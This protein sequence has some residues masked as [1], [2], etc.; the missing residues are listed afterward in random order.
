MKNLNFTIDPERLNALRTNQG[1]VLFRIAF[2]LIALWEI[3]LCFRGDWIA[4][5]AASDTFHFSYTGFGWL[6][7]LPPLGI[8]IL[9]GVLGISAALVAVGLFYPIASGVLSA[10]WIYLVL[11]ERLSFRNDH[12]LL[13]LIS[14]LL[15]LAPAHTRWSFDVLRR[16]SLWTHMVPA[17]YLT[18]LQAQFG[19]V[20]AFIMLELW[21]HWRDVRFGVGTFSLLLSAGLLLFFSFSR[22][23]R[24]AVDGVPPQK[25]RSVP[26]LLFVVYLLVQLVF[27]M[28]SYIYPGNPAWTGE[29]ALAAWMLKAKEMHCEVSYRIVSPTGRTWEAH[30][31]AALP[32]KVYAAM[33]C[34]PELILQY[35]K[36][37]L[38]GYDTRGLAYQIYVVSGAELAGHPRQPL[39]D[40]RVDLASTSEVS[41]F[42]R[43]WIVQLK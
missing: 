24:R 13:A 20:Y 7:V 4:T 14:F 6:G 41:P 18:L 42:L 29:G 15:A 19:V 43:P 31:S 32:P 36:T 28:R 40:P 22:K 27:P 11:L 26:T 33:A 8:K 35:A 5:Y 34:Q 30:P 21:F 39:I 10:G 9:F 1:L 3:F 17:W 2:G 37:L 12:Y 38:D 23:M 25:T 16:K